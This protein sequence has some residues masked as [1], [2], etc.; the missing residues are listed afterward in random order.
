MARIEIELADDLRDWA[1][2]NA[3]QNEL[4]VDAYIEVLLALESGL[5]RTARDGRVL[6]TR[7]FVYRDS[8]HYLVPQ[9]NGAP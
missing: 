6:R 1:A 5:A 3:A 9:T 2:K 4:S 8:E 7:S